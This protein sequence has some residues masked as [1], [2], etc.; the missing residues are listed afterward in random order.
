MALNEYL[1][2]EIALDHAEGHISRREALRLLVLLGVSATTAKGLLDVSAADAATKKTPTTT[3]KPAT[4]SKAKTAPTTRKPT[5]T[6][7]PLTTSTAGSTT[8]VASAGELPA[9][10]AITFAG[11]A[12]PLFASFAGALKPKGAVLII[13]ENRGLTDHFQALPA[14]FARDGYSALAID[15]ASRVGG[16][17]AVASQMPAPLANARTEDLVADMKAGLDELGKRAPGVKLAVTGFCFGGGMVWNLLNVGDS[18]LTAAVPFYGT[19]P[20]PVDFSKSPNAAVMPIYAEL[21][22]RVNANRPAMTA[23]LEKAKLVHQIVVAPGVDHAFFNDTG[24]RYNPTQAT[25]MYGKVLDWFGKY[26]TS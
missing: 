3:K 19:G 18:R 17:A 8:P 10:A 21:D 16:T 9:V 6:P 12:G 4:K 15:L 26:V 22:S 5:T 14:R 13:H 24:A 2:E 20:D 25:A 7:A 1:T 23:A 11:P